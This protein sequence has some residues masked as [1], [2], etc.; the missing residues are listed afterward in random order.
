MDARPVRHDA[1][2]TPRSPDWR[3]RRFA[4]S[5]ARRRPTKR[6]ARQYA[7]F[8]GRDSA[9]FRNQ[10][11]TEEKRKKK[12][13]RKRGIVIGIAATSVKEEAAAR[14]WRKSRKWVA[15]IPVSAVSFIFFYI[16]ICFRSES[17]FRS[18][19]GS[20]AWRASLAPSLAWS[21]KRADSMRCG[22]STRW[23]HIPRTPQCLVRCLP[24][25]IPCTPACVPA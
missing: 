3:Q 24:G 8:K 25:N 14:R 5:A 13:R 4:I 9:G 12:R 22:R 20:V 18:H 15:A 19:F 16:D 2:G 7:L 17:S 6:G 21:G 10:K 1:G 23:P 11:T